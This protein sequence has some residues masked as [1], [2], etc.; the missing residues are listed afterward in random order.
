[1]LVAESAVKPRDNVGSAPN[2]RKDPQSQEIGD[3][4]DAERQHAVF[5]V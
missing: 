3:D 2:A 1:M 5:L 4:S